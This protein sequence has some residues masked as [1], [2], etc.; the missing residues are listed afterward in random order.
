MSDL[1]GCMCPVTAS[2]QQCAGMG[3]MF[4]SCTRLC[5]CLPAWSFVCGMDGLCSPSWRR[6]S[7]NLVCCYWAQ[8][9]ALFSTELYP[10]SNLFWNL[11][12]SWNIWTSVPKWFLEHAACRLWESVLWIPVALLSGSDCAVP[13][14]PQLEFFRT[15]RGIKMP[16][17]VLLLHG[18][19]STCN[20]E[21]GFKISCFFKFRTFLE[22]PRSLHLILLH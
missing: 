1:E 19:G 15:L 8:T 14:K 10:V 21:I 5:V 2:G 16:L 6:G 12:L 4:C 17:S 3:R 7:P 9:G 22:P 20:P 18:L 11:Y 13:F